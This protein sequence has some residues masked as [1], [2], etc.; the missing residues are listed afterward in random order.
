[1]PP[2]TTFS[3]PRNEHQTNSPTIPSGDGS[4]SGHQ[5]SNH[6]SIIVGA[7]IGGVSFIVIVTS[8]IVWLIRRF[9]RRQRESALPDLFLVDEGDPILNPFIANGIT[10]TCPE[11]T[12]PRKRE[13]PTGRTSGTNQLPPVHA[14]LV[15]EEDAEDVGDENHPVE[16]LPPR[17]RS[18]RRNPI[19]RGSDAPVIPSGK[20]AL[21]T[22]NPDPPSRPSSPAS[23]VYTF[24]PARSTLSAS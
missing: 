3:N 5:G 6:A 21:R 14:L 22:R 19:T 17:Y 20:Q 24:Y 18:G 10:R 11:E 15:Q 2:L 9:L 12:G 13:P 16:V 8:L 23:T 4:E 1:M 7:V